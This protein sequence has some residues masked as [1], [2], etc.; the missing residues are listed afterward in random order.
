MI[1]NGV[2]EAGA[3]EKEAGAAGAAV[4]VAAMARNFS[5]FSIG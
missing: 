5:N 4:V 1:Q 2:G 3:E